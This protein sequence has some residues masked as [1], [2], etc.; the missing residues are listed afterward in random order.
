MLC[1]QRET[2]LVGYYAKCVQVYHGE[3]GIVVVA[4]CLCVC[5]SVCHQCD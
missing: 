3:Q 2:L 4:V 1:K 5:L